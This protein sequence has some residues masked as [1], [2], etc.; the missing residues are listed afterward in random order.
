M[1]SGRDPGAGVLFREPAH[2]GGVLPYDGCT[3]T[4]KAGS[5]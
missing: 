2:A 1:T 4:A 5:S 3:A